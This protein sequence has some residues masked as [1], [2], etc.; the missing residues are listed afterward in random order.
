LREGAGPFASFLEDRG[1]AWRAPG[2]STIQYLADL[3]VLAAKPLLVHV[4]DADLEDLERIRSS[5]ASVAHCPKSNAKLCHGIAPLLELVSAG[6]KTGL[7]T[8]GAVSSNNCDLFEEARFAVLLQRTRRDATDVGMQGLDARAM[9]RLATL[10][11]AE[12]LGLAS[13]IGSLEPGKLADLTVVDF[14]RAHHQPVSDPE[15]SVL[16]SASAGD[17]ML[18]MV[19]GRVLYRDGLVSTLDE[20]ALREGMGRTAIKLRQ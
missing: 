1:I 6:I 19:D 5:G 17:V 9:L 15:A 10:G 20:A 7:G 8:D 4:V 2:V 18:T 11:G 12:A 16:F 14:S 3:G 13:E